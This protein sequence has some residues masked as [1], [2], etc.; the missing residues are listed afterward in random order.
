MTVVT[1]TVT[2]AITLVHQ[3]TVACVV[4]LGAL[5]GLVVV[6]LRGV[7]GELLDKQIWLGVWVLVWER[8]VVARKV[9]REVPRET[10][11]LGMWV[12]GGGGS[13][14]R[15][16]TGAVEGTPAQPLEQGRLGLGLV[17]IPRRRQFSRLVVGVGV[18]GVGLLG[19]L[20]ALVGVVGA[21]MAVGCRPAPGVVVGGQELVLVGALPPKH[22]GGLSFSFS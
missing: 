8:E 16:V 10:M 14:S 19:A 3:N 2:T 6:V 17:V 13:S 9:M 11:I 21:A 15:V 18:V 1:A 5:A 20:R 22:I 7:Q 4:A 12:L